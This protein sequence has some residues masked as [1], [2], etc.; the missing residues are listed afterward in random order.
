MT[1]AATTAD[2]AAALL[3]AHGLSR[4]FPGPPAGTLARLRGA[5]AA[6]VHAVEDV[7][8]SVAPHE[9]L[10]LVGESGCGKSTLGRMLAGILPPSAGEVRWRG[11]PVAGLRGAA[12]RDWTLGVQMVFQDP[13]ASLTPRRRVVDLVGEAP[14]LHGLARRRDMR[15]Y[16]ADVLGEVGLDPA[17]ALDRLPHQFSGGQRQRIGIARALAVRPDALVCDE[18]VSALDVSVQAQVVNLLADLRARRG[19]ALLFI[20]HDLSVVRHLSDRVAVMYLGRI[21]EEAPAARLFAAPAHPYT[22]AL[23]RQMPKLEPGRKRFEALPGELPSALR[24]PPGC[25]FHP[26]CPNAFDR[27]RAERPRLQPVA[28]GQRA[29]CH[30][31]GRPA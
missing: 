4:R 23:L 14:V 17:L 13:Q 1:P 28:P 12:A 6:A 25:A 7:S 11:R 31:H 10:G 5:R 18:A 2:A 8:L 3:G 26:R 27:C 21:V 16:V 29:A 20:S 9:A 15:A 19:L 22:A 24:P 30:L